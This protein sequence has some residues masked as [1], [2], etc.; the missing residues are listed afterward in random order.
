MTEI[1]P[2]IDDSLTLWRVTIERVD[3][4]AKMTMTAPDLDIAL[5]ELARYT[6]SDVERA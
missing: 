3:L 4:V 1:R 6:A 5:E 2:S